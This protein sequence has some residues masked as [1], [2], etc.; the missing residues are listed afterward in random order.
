MKKSKKIIIGLIF[1]ILV[2]AIIYVLKYDVTRVNT[3]LVGESDHW[4]ASYTIKGYVEF[5]EK[6]G[7]LMSSSSGSYELVLTYKGDLEEIKDITSIGVSSD[8][9]GSAL[10]SSEPMPSAHFD[11]KGNTH[12]LTIIDVSQGKPL[13]YQVTWD[14]ESGGQETI[15]LKE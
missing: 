14:G 3:V 1:I 15:I 13:E 12:M 9:G 2:I 4:Q 8:S 5:H 7:V 11:F 6:E 10:T